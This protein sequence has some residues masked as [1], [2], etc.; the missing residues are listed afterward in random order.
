MMATAFAD[1]LYTYVETD[2]DAARSER[3]GSTDLMT[4]AGMTSPKITAGKIT[5]MIL[6][7]YDTAGI[8]EL[9]R[10]R[11]ALAAVMAEACDLL[12]QAS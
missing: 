11:V 5:G 7:A 9:L 1:L 8:C 12:Q 10:D 3:Y 6:A 2:L 4:A